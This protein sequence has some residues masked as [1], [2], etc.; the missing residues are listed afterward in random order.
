MSCFSLT[1][2][3]Q[4]SAHGELNGARRKLTAEEP[5]VRGLKS[6]DSTC[7][8]LPSEIDFTTTDFK[9]YFL[10][11]LSMFVAYLCMLRVYGSASFARSCG[12]LKAFKNMFIHFIDSV[13]LDDKMLQ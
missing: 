11:I 13:G 3:G 4:V 7:S 12:S 6:P 2:D 8:L 9:Q 5:Y 1:D 10:K